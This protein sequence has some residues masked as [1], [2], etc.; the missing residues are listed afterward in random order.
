MPEVPVGAAGENFLKVDAFLCILRH[1]FAFFLRFGGGAFPLP[2]GYA[3]VA[4]EGSGI[5]QIVFLANTNFIK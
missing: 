4:F 5:L 2:P 3:T 1:F